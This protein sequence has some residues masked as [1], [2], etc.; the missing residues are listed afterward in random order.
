[1]GS[2]QCSIH[3]EALF[4]RILCPQRSDE[5]EGRTERHQALMQEGGSKSRKE[6][7]RAAHLVADRLLLEPQLVQDLVVEAGHPDGLGQSWVLTLVKG[8]GEQSFRKDNE[9]N[10]CWKIICQQGHPSRI[11]I[12]YQEEK[13]SCDT[14]AK[15][16]ISSLEKPLQDISHV[17]KK[18]PA[19]TVPGSPPPFLSVNI[20]AMVSSP[21]PQH[22]SP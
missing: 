20:S 9:Q 10:K 22:P 3:T 21:K 12:D 5:Q 19:F 16:T 13:R 1:M 15:I 11:S 18:M 7:S 2:I 6:R 14:K 8:C 17:R 4:S